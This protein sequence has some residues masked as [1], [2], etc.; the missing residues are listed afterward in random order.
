[1]TTQLGTFKK[2]GTPAGRI[3]SIFF[4][5]I[6]CRPSGC[7]SFFWPTSFF[8]FCRVQLY[9]YPTPLCEGPEAVL[10]YQLI[11][12]P[13]SFWESSQPCRYIGTSRHTT[14]IQWT[15]KVMKLPDGR[16]HSKLAK[17]RPIRVAIEIC[18]RDQIAVMRRILETGVHGRKAYCLRPS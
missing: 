13:P 18:P 14:V 1:M 12:S 6:P 5:S 15:R 3:L 17:H 7:H 10:Y 16:R 4:Y 11:S 2:T 8:V 9:H